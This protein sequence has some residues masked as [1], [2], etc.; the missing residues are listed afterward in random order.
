L[1]THDAIFH[2]RTLKKYN[3]D[4]IIRNIILGNYFMK[5][6]SKYGYNNRETKEA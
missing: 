3:Y 1:Q 2:N 4:K 5:I 6:A